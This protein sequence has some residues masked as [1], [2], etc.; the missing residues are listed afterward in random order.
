MSVFSGPL[1]ILFFW[2]FFLIGVYMPVKY[3]NFLCSIYVGAL[4]FL[5]LYYRAISNLYALVEERSSRDVHLLPNPI[6][7]LEKVKEQNP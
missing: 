5:R 2:S 3:G 7:Q 4:F 6:S 1:A